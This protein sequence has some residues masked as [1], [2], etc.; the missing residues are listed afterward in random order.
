MNTALDWR[1]ATLKNGF[2]D[3]TA[4]RVE[5]FSDIVGSAI[6]PAA[7]QLVFWH[8]LFTLGG[9]TE[10]AGMTFTDM[11]HYTIVS[12]L[13]SQ[14]RGGDQDFEL[15]EMIRTGTLSNYLLRPVSVVEFIYLR[16][17]APRFL[18]AGLSLILGLIL[19]LWLGG[20]SPVR[21]CGAMVMAVM[22]NVIHY[23]IGAVLSTMGFY[24]E[25]AYSMLMVKNL[26]VSILSGELLPLNLFPASM[27][28]IWESTPFYLYVFGPTQYALGRWTHLEFLHHLG[29]ALIWMLGLWFLIRMTW[30]IGI[31]RYLSLG[32]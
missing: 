4:Y 5:F 20:A 29:I 28:W 18:I 24:W 16:G 1:A 22:G 14:V 25:D 17:A 6:V 31:R 26:V 12:V 27:R 11:I 8:A 9:A 3:A 13:F 30:K 19:S 7:I 32:G 2:R 10:V 21:V 15:G 23:Q